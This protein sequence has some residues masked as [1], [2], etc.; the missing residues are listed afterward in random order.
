MWITS[1]IFSL[2]DLSFIIHVDFSYSHMDCLIVESQLKLFSHVGPFRI[3]KTARKDYG[4]ITVWLEVEAL[5]LGLYE[6]FGHSETSSQACSYYTYRE[7]FLGSQIFSNWIICQ[8]ASINWWSIYC[9]LQD[10]DRSF[11]SNQDSPTGLK[12]SQHLDFWSE[13]CWNLAFLL[14]SHIGFHF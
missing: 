8:R 10:D 11:K 7:S 9:C 1:W 6:I 5:G 4:L 3:S 14:G 13:A 12:M 2:I